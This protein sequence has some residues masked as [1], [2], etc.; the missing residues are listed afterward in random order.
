[1]RTGRRSCVP[2][3]GIAG[4]ARKPTPVVF[5]ISATAASG[6]TGTR[7]SPAR[8]LSVARSTRRTAT[9]FA[10]SMLT[11]LNASFSR[12]SIA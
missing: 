6:P 12:P 9:F 7:K 5:A 4:S 11:A 2:P 8:R 10:S 1:M 3:A